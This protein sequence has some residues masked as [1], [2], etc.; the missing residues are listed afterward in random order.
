MV[1]GVVVGLLAL[2]YVVLA[3]DGNG[4]GDDSDAAA[5]EGSSDTT[6]AGSEPLPQLEGG[7]PLRT[8]D[9]TVVVPEGWI[10]VDVT[11]TTT[12]PGSE[13]FPDNQ[14]W[15][16]LV[17]ALVGANPQAELV[18]MAVDRAG[19]IAGSP[20]MVLGFRAVQSI[21]ETGL[22]PALD[23]M[24]AAF[25]VMG[26]L[27]PPSVEVVSLGNRTAGRLEVRPTAGGLTF[28]AYS[29]PG[30]DGSLLAYLLVDGVPPVAADIDRSA[31]TFRLR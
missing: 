18:L 16:Q 2:G 17:D 20:A 22:E 3:G 30:T 4:D 8:L 25:G 29:F 7:T 24:L 31:I 13:L 9:A 14:Q 21:D 26:A 6:E 27:D 19:A 1:A 15:L 28:V 23:G 10:N 11:A 12:T 5:S